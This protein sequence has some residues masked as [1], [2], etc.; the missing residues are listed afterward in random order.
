MRQVAKY[1]RLSCLRKDREVLDCQILG[2]HQAAILFLR[3]I[4]AKEIS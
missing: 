1:G 3:R 2:G 4:T